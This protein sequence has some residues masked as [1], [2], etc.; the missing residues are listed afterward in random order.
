MLYGTQGTSQAQYHDMRYRRTMPDGSERTDD[1]LYQ[2]RGYY[3]N[4]ETHGMHYGEF[5]NYADHFAAAIL[6]GQV[7]AP[8]LREGIETFCVLEAV[9]RS[10]A[11]GQP[12]AIAPILREAGLG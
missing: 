4:N 12:C 11:S 8:D 7:A 1:P 2:L 6:A 3:F 9:R 5:A 10:A